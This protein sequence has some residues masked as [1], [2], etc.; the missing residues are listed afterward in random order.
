M[1]STK[2]NSFVSFALLGAMIVF[3]R[4]WLKT[5][6]TEQ[7]IASFAFHWLV[8]HHGADCTC[9]EVGLF[10]LL[11]VALKHIGQIKAV[12]I[13]DLLSEWLKSILKTIGVSLLESLYLLSVIDLF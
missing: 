1:H 13:S 8:H 2:F 4:P 6:L 10:S 7:G 3:A 9:K 5:L 11:F 12:F